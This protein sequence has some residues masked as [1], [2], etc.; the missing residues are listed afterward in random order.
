[1][2][3][4]RL[5]PAA[6]RGS[7]LL[8]VVASLLLLTTLVVAFLSRVTFER[9]LASASS[10]L[11]KTDLAAQGAVTMIIG[12]LQNEIIAGSNSGTPTLASGYLYP[13]APSTVVPCLN[14][15]GYTS[16]S[17]VGT[18]LEDLVKVSKNGTAFYSGTGY[19]SSGPSRAAP[20]NTLANPS[21]NNRYITTARWNKPLFLPKA[22]PTSSTDFT[23]VSAFTAPDWIYV[24][25]DGSN[26]TSWDSSYTFSPNISPLG[27]PT[28][29]SVGTNAVTQRYAYAIYDEG[30]TLD[31]NVVGSPAYT[32]ST[33][34]LTYSPNSAYKNA[35][36]YA[37]LSQLPYLSSTVQTVAGASTGTLSPKQQAYFVDAIAG[38]RNYASASYTGT[39]TVSFSFTATGTLAPQSPV[40]GMFPGVTSAPALPY[41]FPGTITNTT[42]TP[43][44]VYVSLNPFGFMTTSAASLA[45]MTTTQSNPNQSDN[46]FVSRQQLISFLTQGIGQ[47]TTFATSAAYLGFSS[48]GA[49]QA[50][51]QNVLPYLGTFSRDLSQPSFAPPTSFP[52]SVGAPTTAT[53]ANGGN[54]KGGGDTTINPAFLAATVSTAF[55]RN[56]GSTAL[57]GDPLVKKRFALMRLAWL[58]YQG[59]SALRNGVSGSTTASST[60]GNADYDIYQMENTYGIPKSFLAL[61][62]AQNIYKY[63]GLSWVQ[64]TRSNGDNQYKW[65]YN[66]ESSAYLTALPS[67]AALI[68]IRTLSSGSNTV[69]AKAREADFFELLKAATTLGS[70][71]KAYLLVPAAGASGLPSNYLSMP[72]TFEATRDNSVDLQI[73]QMGANIINQFQPSGYTARILFSDGLLYSGLGTPLQEIRG[74]VDLPYIYR[75]REGKITIQDC[76]IPNPSGTGTWT[77]A[78]LP[79]ATSSSGTITSSTVT[80]SN[81]GL[82]AVMQE[83]EIWN[84]HSYNTSNPDS[85]P[86]PTQ[87]RIVAYSTDPNT[88]SSTFPPT[89]NTGST[90]ISPTLVCNLNDQGNSTKQLFC[91]TSLVTSGAWNESTTEMD[92]TIPL[93]STNANYNYNLFRE[94]TL[95]IKPGIPTGS[96]LAIGANNLIATNFSSSSTTTGTVTTGSTTLGSGATYI[97]SHWPATQIYSNV[98]YTTP[99]IDNQQYIGFLGGYGPAAWFVSNLPASAITNGNPPT[100]GAGI[101]EVCAEQEQQSLP[102]TYRMQYKDP[103]GN[104]VTYD[105]KA[106]DYICANS[107]GLDA[108][109]FDPERRT[110][111]PGSNNCLTPYPAADNIIGAEAAE[112][113]I[114]PRTGRFGM[115]PIGPWGTDIYYFTQSAQTA[116]QSLEFPITE[117]IGPGFGAPPHG[118]TLAIGWAASTGIDGAPATG[119]N[120]HFPGDGSSGLNF[121]GAISQLALTTM[122]PDWC[123]GYTNC[124][125]SYLLSINQLEGGLDA[126]PNV[127][128]WYPTTGVTAF[129]ATT[130]PPYYSTQTVMLGMM[131]Q[132]NPAEV[133]HD[134]SPQHLCYDSQPEM[135]QFNQYFSDPDGVVRRAMGA[136]VPV[137]SAGNLPATANVTGQPSGLPMDIGTDYTN[138][139][140]TG[141]VAIPAEQASRPIMLNRPFR[142][143]GDLDYVFSGTPWRSLDVGTPESG[144]KALLDV[145]CINDT[146]DPNGLVAGK[147][148]LNTRQ[149]PVLTAVLAGAYR[150]EFSPT[151]TGSFTPGPIPPTYA[152]ALAGALVART[153]STATGQGPLANVSELAGKWNAQVQPVAVTGTITELDGSKSYV[154]FSSDLVNTISND[155]KLAQTAALITDN[156]TDNA[157]TR[158]ERFRNAPIRAL[159]NAGTT[160]VWNLMIDVIAQTGRFPS[161]ASNLASFNVEGERRY[162]VHV[163][164]DRYTGKVLDEQIEEVK[165]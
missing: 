94:P 146:E 78:N 143:V 87:F 162:W 63:F 9:Q 110:F 151:T 131:S 90:T 1:M 93:K 5:R 126:G 68:P 101:A 159:A 67:G 100:S 95:L 99:A 111:I 17:I 107:Y 41:Q 48:T 25:R 149:V 133:A 66:H 4:S 11:G 117:V 39:S 74:V 121:N 137:P 85:N 123:G 42:L 60:P 160:R 155:I 136:Y 32:N 15:P 71:G 75:M 125:F 115:I 45:S 52:A 12:D 106:A 73:L 23:P 163:A 129:G 97:Y 154:G 142:S 21:I 19:S 18:G 49:C 161:S 116:G 7:A 150:D 108:P 14:V 124:N 120:A 98:P 31:M 70:V 165:E 27:T 82:V 114:D 44:D 109:A 118:F 13:S 80:S 10:G 26:P 37:D 61:G 16:S 6:R 134:S 138:A 92:F 141:P 50:A 22:T 135:A 64:D 2:H 144:S 58:T 30:S 33:G 35:I 56:D 8:L 157:D 34:S 145:F 51:M 84:P 113:C 43:F 69:L 38:W 24:A 130:L 88:A 55:T 158:V 47:N 29:G 112:A 89:T 153:S 148:N 81:Q 103:S 40:T 128:G 96:N 76:A 46:A 147:V 54:D 77:M 152:A 3:L 127:P 65:V 164:L 28:L 53:A 20:V 132:N 156:T 119:L 139:T 72:Y 79:Q 86:R 57:V 83:P 104:W 140:T 62:T 122:R 91:P 102:I 59:P 36:A 105:E